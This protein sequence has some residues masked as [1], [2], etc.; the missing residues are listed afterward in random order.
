MKDP[1]PVAIVG[2]C[3]FHCSL[4]VLPSPGVFEVN[5]VR[6]FNRC[7]HVRVAVAVHVP[8]RH[9]F[10]R[11]GFGTFGKRDGLPAMG[12]V[13]PVRDPDVPVGHA[14]VLCVGLVNRD[15]I[16]VAVEAEVRHG[17]PIA[18]GELDPADRDIVD[19]VLAPGDVLPVGVSRVRRSVTNAER[20]IR[21][22]GRLRA[23]PGQG[24][25]SRRSK[26]LAQASF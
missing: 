5:Q 11:T 22:P 4:L 19:E 10:R 6:Q 7:D 26:R 3:R 16:E 13:G 25:P 24:Q 8:D 9:V 12:I 20:R 1:R 18:A 14:V 2:M 17:E 21:R 15:D 23:R